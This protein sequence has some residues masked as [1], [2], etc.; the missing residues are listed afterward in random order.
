[1]LYMSYVRLR[2]IQSPRTYQIEVLIKKPWLVMLAFWALGLGFYI[3]VTFGFGVHDFSVSVQ[4]SPPYLT[5]IFNFFTWM[6]PMI[7]NAIFA[8]LVMRELHLRNK[9]KNNMSQHHKQNSNENSIATHVNHSQHLHKRSIQN[10][11]KLCLILPNL[12]PTTRFQI[13]IFSYWFEFYL[14]CAKKNNMVLNKI[15]LCFKLSFIQV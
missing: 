12:K 13:I 10:Q 14:F 5:S 2:S 9:K 6:I 11:A 15:N 8:L 3:P 1:M 7:L 4:Y